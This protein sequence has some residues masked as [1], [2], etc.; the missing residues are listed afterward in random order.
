MNFFNGF[1]RW[2][3]RW[4]YSLNIANCKYW[5]DC[6]ELVMFHA[7]VHSHVLQSLLSNLHLSYCKCCNS[8]NDNWCKHK[9]I[10]HKYRV[11]CSIIQLFMLKS[12]SIPILSECYNLCFHTRLVPTLWTWPWARDKKSH[13]G[14]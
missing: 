9:T 7:I 5:I 4:R 14:N 11:Y 10:R 8:T 13:S 6:I 1:F 12:K 3:E 2:C